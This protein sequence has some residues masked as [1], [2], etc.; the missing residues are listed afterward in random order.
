[1]SRRQNSP[2]RRVRRAFDRAALKRVCEMHEHEFPT[3][4]PDLGT[5]V[6]EERQYNNYFYFA[7]RGSDILFV[8][9]LDTVVHHE[10]R[11]CD[12]AE[13]KAG[14]VVHSGTLDDRLGAYIGLE[15][16]P[17][18]L[19]DNWADV[20]LTVGEESGQSTAEFFDPALHAGGKQY[21]WIIEF[22]RKGTDV[23]M[24]SYQDFETSARVRDIGAVVG[25]GSVSDISYMTGL[26]CKA[27]NWG[28]GYGGDYHSVKGYAYL[29][30]TYKMVLLF[31]KFYAANKDTMLPHTK[32][33]GRGK[34]S[35]GYSGYGY[36][37]GGYG[38]SDWRSRS[39][40]SR[41]W[42]RDDDDDKIVIG[43]KV[44]DSYEDWWKDK[45]PDEDMVIG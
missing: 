42:D 18:L 20:L 3:Q 33:S 2:H 29:M 6:T 11:L 35:S 9:H 40:G 32:G 41:W 22:D 26:G 14:P 36:S 37:G 45:Y 39:S 38:G 10:D 15:L 27:F 34:G 28:T 5:Y 16:I 25:H 23:V 17:K 1:M 7:D 12:F 31:L 43:G 30:D 4:Y 13:T 8:A 24:Y 21:K 44:Y 19:G